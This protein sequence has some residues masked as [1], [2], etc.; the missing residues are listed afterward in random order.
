MPSDAERQGL[1]SDI[2]V[3]LQEAV[4]VLAPIAEPSGPGRPRILPDLCLWLGL[5]VCVLKGF[6]S[7]LAVWRLLSWTGLWHYPRFPVS[8]QAIYKRLEKGSLAALSH[9]FDQITALLIEKVE[10][11]VDQSLAPFAR[12]VFA[13]DTT[14]L[15]KVARILPALRGLPDKDARLLPGKLGGVFDI[16]RQL[17]REIKYVESSTENDKVSAPVL[18]E[19]LEAS[20][21]LLF[22]LGYFGFPWFDGLTEQGLFWVSRLR[23]KTSYEVL[24]TFYQRDGVFD[25]IINLGAYR[26]DRAAYAVRLVQYPVGDNTFRYITNVLEPQTLPLIEI[27]RL[28]AR[29]WDI[30]LAFRLVKR[31]LRLHLI[32][33]GK[34][35]VIQQQIWAVL[36][37]AQILQAMRTEIAARAGVDPFDVSM[38]LLV[39]YIPELTS[40]GIDPIE[41]FVERGR[42]ARFIRPSR[43]TQIKAPIIPPEEINPLPPDL[44]LQRKARCSRRNYGSR[45]QN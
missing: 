41:A 42:E 43:R 9:I 1:I 17:W 36:I 15:D 39:Q 26:A 30:E 11:F 24:H 33:S 34:P 5:I 40:M 19:G 14:T 27:A 29:R 23:N 4:P 7:Q 12:D 28:Y 3:W 31:E 16:R 18:V 10:P 6:E 22:D 35:L 37:I 38:K 20:T 8:D 45:S 44:V 13:I 32:W 2:E 21:L 25:G